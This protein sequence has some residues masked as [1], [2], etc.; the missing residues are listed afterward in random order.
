MIDPTIAIRRMR[1]DE[2]EAFRAIR[3]EALALDP[4]A[5]GSTLQAE[6]EESLAFFVERLRHSAVFG[7]F[8]GSDLLGIVGFY[9]LSDAKIRHKG[10]LWCMYVRTGGRGAGVG[11]AL[12]EAVIEH[13]EPRVELLQLSVVTGKISARRLYERLGF[14]EYGVEERAMKHGGAYFDEVLMVKF[15]TDDRRGRRESDGS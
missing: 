13:A 5:F 8:R 6:A 11:K 10:V 12:V 9:P 15:L 14:V 2:A 4:D 1:P 3:L 7:A